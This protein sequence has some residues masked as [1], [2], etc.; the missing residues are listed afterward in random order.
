[1]AETIQCRSVLL[2][3]EGTVA[4]VEFVYDVMFPYIR[5]HVAAFL[6]NHWAVEA[7]Q[8]AVALVGQDVGREDTKQW[9]SSCAAGQESRANVDAQQKVVV[10]AVHQ[11]MDKDAKVTGLKQLQGLIWK[12]GFTSGQLVAE[13]FPD[14]LPKLKEWQAAGLK[15]YIYSSGCIAA[16]KLFFGHTTQGDLLEMFVDHFDTTSGNK[17]QA[18]S[19]STIASAIGSDPATICFISDVQAELD[20][21]ADAGM[22]TVFRPTKEA[23]AGNDCP[24]PVI[25][26]FDELGLAAA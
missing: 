16:Q 23:A 7:V 20:A 12:D 25:G 14:V 18:A 24:H 3:I 17:K 19:Y 10:D 5:E 11:L 8:N 2:D 4:P 26:S 1:M 6:S 22:K 13:L 21:A 15:L 9:L